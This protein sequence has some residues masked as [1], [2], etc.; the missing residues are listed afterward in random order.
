MKTCA[1]CEIEKLTFAVKAQYR[2]LFEL[3]PLVG[4]SSTERRIE[5]ARDR[6]M[7]ELNGIV[8]NWRTHVCTHQPAIKPETVRPEEVKPEPK[9]EA[10]E[11]AEESTEEP[12]I[13]SSAPKTKKK[14]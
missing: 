12:I 11:P 8:E 5:P 1:R 14:K 10:E 6:A 2:I 7:K 13:E 3:I 4:L 9:A